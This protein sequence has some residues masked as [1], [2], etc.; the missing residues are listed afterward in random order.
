MVMSR[1]QLLKSACYVAT[2]VFVFAAS[3]TCLAAVST[4]TSFSFDFNSL[5]SG[6]DSTSGED[7][8]ENYME[9][10][11]GSEITLKTGART[12]K[13]KPENGVGLPLYLGNSENGVGNHPTNYN[14][15][16]DTYLYNR[17]KDGYDRITIEFLDVPV[18]HVEFDWQIFAQTRG[19][20]D[21]TFKADDVVIFY[22][23]NSDS[24][25]IRDGYMNHF[26][27]TFASPVK[28]LEFVDWTT[29]PV[30]IDNLSVTTTHTPEPASLLMWGLGAAAFTYAGYRRRS[31]R[32]AA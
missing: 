8:I 2:L 27:H 23:D 29:A 10:I 6:I 19:K 25:T 1:Q 9:A 32:V 30:G 11:Y 15:N 16:K 31:R 21:F 28:K 5:S 22:Y 12:R 7:S 18:T 20:A 4:T 14:L 24:D 26:S 13:D 3:G 17:W